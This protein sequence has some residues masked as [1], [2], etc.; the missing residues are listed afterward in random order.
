MG[1]TWNSI[2]QTGASASLDQVTGDLPIIVSNLLA[3]R[4]SK[5]V[6]DLDQSDIYIERSEDEYDLDDRIESK[7]QWILDNRLSSLGWNGS[8]GLV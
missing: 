7:Q 5:V 2:H 1:Q 3:P 6:Y 4:A 8:S